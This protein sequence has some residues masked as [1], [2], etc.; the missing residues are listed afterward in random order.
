MND[1]LQIVSVEE[2]L[3]LPL[4]IP[5]YQRPYTWSTKSASVLF[6][7]IQQACEDHL[8][9]YRIGSVIL[10]RNGDC[11]EVVD[12]QQRLTTL[13]MLLYCLDMNF[14]GGL[15]KQNYKAASRQSLANNYC[16]LSQLCANLDEDAR[17]YMKTYIQKRCSVVVIEVQSEQ[18][19][20]QFFDSQNSRGKELAPHDLLKSY[21]LREMN[22]ESVSEK[23]KI[24][25][26]WENTNQKL[27]ANIFENTLYPLVRW[28]KG[29]GG[30]GYSSKEID[31]FKGVQRNN[32]F[33]YSIYHRSA[34]LYIEQANQ[35]KIYELMSNQKICQFQLTQPLIAGRRF[36]N[37]TL[38]Y[39][40]LYQTIDK[41]MQVLFPELYKGDYKEGQRERGDWLVYNLLVNVAI[42]FMDRFGEKELTDAVCR[43]LFSWVYMLRISLY[44]V[45]EESVNKYALGL[46]SFNNGVNMFALINQMNCP[47]DLY[48][49]PLARPDRKQLDSDEKKSYKERLNMYFDIWNKYSGIKV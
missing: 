40:E 27:I 25:N 41:K 8:A 28:Y 22:D 32:G 7:D 21:H 33:N 24:I 12:G 19:A 16:T 9:E 31:A 29:L 11:F 13:S 43:S 17:Q 15:L 30:L 39:V 14:K 20:F 45:Y 38:H 10:Y 35:N 26:E 42:F 48:S 1:K 49:I 37:Y 46:H 18:E 4:S 6:A 34:N 23:T 2:L 47:K 44:S 3:Q 5:P 36:F